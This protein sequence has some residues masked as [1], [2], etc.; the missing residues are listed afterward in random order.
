MRL[1]SFFVNNFNEKVM[2]QNFALNDLEFHPLFVSQ[3]Y[4][5]IGKDHPLTK[6]DIVSVE[7]LIQYPNITF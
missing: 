2:Y 3:P 7:D 6:K 1:E 4:I 5:F